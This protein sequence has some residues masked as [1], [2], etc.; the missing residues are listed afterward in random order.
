MLGLVPRICCVRQVVENVEPPTAQMPI[1]Q[2]LGTSPRMTALKRVASSGV[3]HG[4]FGE[5]LG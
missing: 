1:W 4:S 3:P 5:R 2:I